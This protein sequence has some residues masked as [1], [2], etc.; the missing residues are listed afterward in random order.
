M[1]LTQRFEEAMKKLDK[2][3]ASKDYK[4]FK[5]MSK[6]DKKPSDKLFKDTGKDN[7]KKQQFKTIMETPLLS[8][9]KEIAKNTY[10]LGKG[11]IKVDE[12]NKVI[13]ILKSVGTESLVELDFYAKSLKYTIKWKK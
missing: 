3:M 9:A 12:P 6:K 7:K 2:A 13:E 5:P 8:K 1:K 10:K 4:D 11:S